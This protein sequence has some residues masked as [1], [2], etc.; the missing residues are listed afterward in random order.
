MIKS[1]YDYR[2]ENLATIM[3]VAR[4]AG[5]S[6]TTVSRVLNDSPL[7]DKETRKRVF[8]AMKELDYQPSLAARNL[9]KQETKLIAVLI[10]NISNLFFASLLE[11]MEGVAAQNGYNIILCNTW[12]DPERELRY[13]RM[14]ENKQVDGVILTALRNPM[15]RVLPYLKYGPIVFASEYLED[16][17]LPA[18]T[19]DNAAASRKAVGHLIALGRQKVAFIN[20]PERFILCGDRRKGYVQA[21][22]EHGLPVRSEWMRQSDFTIVGGF[23]SAQELFALPSPPTAVFAAN[24]EMAIGAIQAIQQLGL[25]VPED[26]A[27]VGF[28]DNPMATV[29]KPSL[30]TIGQPVHRMGAEV[31][32]LLLACLEDKERIAR[33]RRIVLETNLIIRES[34]SL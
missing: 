12:D 9:R 8:A 17:A 27:V 6:R 19:I 26:V 28:D 20:G 15:E 34:S 14:L 3:D 16:D 7:V 10:P 31:I 2:G 13:I 22:E 29:V 32:K 1:V 23:R 11:G 21:L 18:V 25:Q 5:V 4:L 30:S 24:D 33:P